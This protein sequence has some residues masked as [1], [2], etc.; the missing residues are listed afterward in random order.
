MV[1]GREAENKGEK[2]TK[3]VSGCNEVGTILSLKIKSKRSHQKSW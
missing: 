2:G 3:F 1:T